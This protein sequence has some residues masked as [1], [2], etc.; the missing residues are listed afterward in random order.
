VLN[1]ADYWHRRE[2]WLGDRAELFYEHHGVKEYWLINPEARTVEVLFRER[3][4]YRLAG[5]C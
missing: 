2:V 3:G 5:R 4:A 1:P